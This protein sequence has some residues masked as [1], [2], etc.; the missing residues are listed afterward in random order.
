M[1]KT[2]SPKKKKDQEF[3][4]C[5]CGK[6]WKTRDKFLLDKK[7]KLVGYQPDLVNH[8]YNHFLFYHR[9]KGCSQF[10]GIRASS[11]SDLREKGCSKELC[12]GHDDCPGYCTDTLDLR[13]CSVACINASDREL[14]AKISKRRILRSL[15]AVVGS[16]KRAGKK[17]KSKATRAS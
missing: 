5:V 4:D 1:K 9:A 12:M 10:F 7:V 13:V 6:T 16:A 8:K 11:F 3:K 17:E 2:M 14:A 15:N